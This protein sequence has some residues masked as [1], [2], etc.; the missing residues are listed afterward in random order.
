MRSS[1]I[2]GRP[3]S[4][5]GYSGRSRS[6]RRAQGTTCSISAKNLSRRVCFFLPAYSACEKL[7]CPVKNGTR[8]RY[9]ISRP[10]IAESRGATP[11]GLRVPAGEI[12]QLITTRIGEFLS[13]PARLSEALVS[14]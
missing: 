12:E 14:Y 10:L 9:Y 13:D 6:T 3:R 7:P 2:G 4:P 11:E 8:Y 1:P 5:L